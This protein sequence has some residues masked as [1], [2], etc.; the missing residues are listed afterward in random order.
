MSSPQSSAGPQLNY[1]GRT[2]FG[3][4]TEADV[5]HNLVHTN[6]DEPLEANFVIVTQIMDMQFELLRRG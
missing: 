1:E 3:A 4:Y 6:T 5:L 2:P